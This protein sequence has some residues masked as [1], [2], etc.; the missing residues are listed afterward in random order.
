MRLT[1][2]RSHGRRCTHLV[3][4]FLC[5]QLQARE[6]QAQPNASYSEFLGLSQQAL[7]TLQIKFTFL[8]PSFTTVHSHVYTAVGQ[9]PDM[10]Q[11]VACRR[12]E[13][14]YFYDKHD[15]VHV[16][17]TTQE[18]QAAIDSVGTLPQITAGGVDSSGFLSFSMLYHDGTSNK[19]FEAII[20]EER[21]RGL[22]LMLRKALAGNAIAVADLTDQAC[23]NDMLQTLAPTDVTSVVDVRFTPIR[24]DVGSE[25]FVGRATVRNGS[26]QPLPAPLI[27]V[28]Q[29]E[30]ESVELL[31]ADGRTC[32]LEPRRA[33]FV[34]LPVGGG[35]LA[36]GQS[37]EVELRFSNPSRSQVDLYWQHP[38]PSG[39]WVTP[40]V[41]AGSGDR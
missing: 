41:Y 4:L 13:F 15:P 37:I 39:E 19:C 28:V 21:G 8:D 11:F 5:G 1:D 31:N 24:E 7:L 17:A 36:A 10:E 26:G 16:E 30:D 25:V 2:V 20:N 12:P 9:V 27:L 35:G 23:A 14:S 40:R 3:I 22:F 33:Q 32:Q 29:P 34:Q 38:P 18:L 6:L